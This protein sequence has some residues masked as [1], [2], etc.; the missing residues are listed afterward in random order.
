VI[1]I[2]KD[3]KRDREAKLGEDESEFNPEG[4]AQDAV[5]AVVDA[6]A[7]VLPADEDC[8]DDVAGAIWDWLVE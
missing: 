5:L 1:L 2:G 3:A 6:E 4:D 7:L 8:G